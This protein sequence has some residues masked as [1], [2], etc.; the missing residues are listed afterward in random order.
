MRTIVMCDLDGVLAD[1]RHRLHY[2]KNKDYGSFYSYSEVINDSIW[3]RGRNLLGVLTDPSQVELY[4]VT[5]RNEVCRKATE[6]WLKMTAWDK[7]WNDER[8]HLVMRRSDDH[9]ESP[10]VKAEMVEQIIKD[11]YSQDSIDYI[12]IDDDPEN[13]RA[14]TEKFPFVVGLVFGIKRMESKK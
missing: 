3:P 5:G 14:V 2:L 13:V 10:I 7:G 4:Y 8:A 1:N 6:D 12:F 11:T 9:R